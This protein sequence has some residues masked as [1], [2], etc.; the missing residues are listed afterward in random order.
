[1]TRNL[2][3]IMLAGAMLAPAT[4]ASAASSGPE[5]TRAG[6]K[7]AQCL[8]SK[9]KTDVLGALGAS[10][11][12]RAA[13]YANIL[14]NSPAC[15]KVTV[16]TREVEGA[17][18]S[19]PDDILRGMLAEAALRDVRAAS[20]LGP[21]AAERSYARPWFAATGRDAAVDEMA[22][23]MAA[24]HPIGIRKLL[25]TPPE[26]TEE[27]AVIQALGGVLAPCLPEGATFKA[28]RQAFRA[29]LAEAFYHRAEATA[30]AAK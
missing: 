22:V 14:R 16:S 28:N 25:G 20:G 6:H 2:I 4:V 9:R 17:S 24:Q 1:M 21:L 12:E 13:Y 8:Y 7:L 23:C 30:V 10:S 5:Y 15:A 11:A 27:L 3:A 19:A 18:V 29:A 26:S